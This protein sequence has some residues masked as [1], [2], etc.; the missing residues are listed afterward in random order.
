M[1]ERFILK[2]SVFRLLYEPFATVLEAPASADVDG[3]KLPGTGI[4]AA[5]LRPSSRTYSHLLHQLQRLRHSRP[6]GHARDRLV[7]QISGVGL[8]LC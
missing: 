1:G 4:R 6:R 7:G 2:L 8:P 3:N 5:G